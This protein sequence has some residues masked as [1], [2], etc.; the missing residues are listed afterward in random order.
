MWRTTQPGSIDRPYPGGG[1]GFQQ[2]L[3]LDVNGERLVIASQA[4]SGAPSVRRDEDTSIVN[5][6]V[7]EAP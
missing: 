3:I 4:P 1:S 6:T 2:Y 7:I 5:S